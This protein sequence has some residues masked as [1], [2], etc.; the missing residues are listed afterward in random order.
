MNLNDR[1]REL[2]EIIK[3]HENYRHEVDDRKELSVTL[4]RHVE[5]E[6][7][8]ARVEIEKQIVRNLEAY[9]NMPNASDKAKLNMLQGVANTYK[10]ISIV[11]LT[12]EREGLK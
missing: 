4:A 5:D 1:A 10:E 9:L 2:E 8:K 7:R 11:Q 12:K 6:I 3:V